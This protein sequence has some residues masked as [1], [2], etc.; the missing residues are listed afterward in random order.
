MKIIPNKFFKKEKKRNCQR[1]N[2][3][4][5]FIQIK[6]FRCIVP[7]TGKPILGR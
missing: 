4:T 7:Y 6:F 5:F 1:I 3:R 2:K